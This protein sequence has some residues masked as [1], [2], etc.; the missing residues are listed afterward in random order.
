MKPRDLRRSFIRS[1][2]RTTLQVTIPLLALS[3]LFHTLRHAT[4]FLP[5][6]PNADVPTNVSDAVVANVLDLSLRHLEPP[7]SI[8]AAVCYKALFGTI[9]C[10]I[11]L[12]WVGT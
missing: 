9:D 3:W 6:L 2:Q 5:P 11:V 8:S 12:Q 7:H 4:P 1:L 10:G